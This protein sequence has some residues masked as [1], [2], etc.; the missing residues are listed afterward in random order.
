MV[1]QARKVPEPSSRRDLLFFADHTLPLRNQ[2][3]C[4]CRQAGC[5]LQKL[6]TDLDMALDATG[7]VATALELHDR[8]PETQRP[9]YSNPP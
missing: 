2:V 5:A 3:I 1:G 4:C 9:S 7:E 6:P 8:L